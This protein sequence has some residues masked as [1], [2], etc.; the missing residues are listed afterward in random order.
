MAKI[1]ILLGDIDLEA[2]VDEEV[3]LTGE[4]TDKPIE[5]GSDTSDHFQSNPTIISLSGSVVAGEAASKLAKLRKYHR[6]ATLLRYAG[7]N[8]FDNMIILSMPTRHNA[9]NKGGFD[10]DITLKQ[11][12]L[13]KPETFEVKVANPVTKKQDKKT[14]IKV[15][16]T[17]NKGRQQPKKKQTRAA[18]SSNVKSTPTLA[19]PGAREMIK[20][21]TTP[22]N[23]LN[24]IK[25]AYPMKK[26]TGKGG[27][28]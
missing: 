3:G 21:D 7:R 15:K 11:I 27:T 6:E 4:T 1:P 8:I 18:S 12:K 19:K 17:T 16:V 24:M 9:N 14:A 28:R 23:T 26:P 22:G 5:K 10:F 13:S 2:V 20:R 25:K